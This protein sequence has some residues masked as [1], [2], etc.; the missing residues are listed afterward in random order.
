MQVAEAYPQHRVATDGYLMEGR[1]GGKER[2]KERKGRRE[3]ES[4]R[5]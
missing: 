1:R 3:E 4:C 5:V 2:R